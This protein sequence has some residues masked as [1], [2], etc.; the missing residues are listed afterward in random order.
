MDIRPIPE[1][2]GYFAGEDGNIYSNRPRAREVGLQPV[3][4]LNPG[5]Q[6]SGKYYIVNIKKNED[7]KYKS[8]R[9]H[10]LVCMAFH[11]VPIDHKATVSHIN[12]NWRN[13]KP[14]NLIWESMSDNH[15]RKKD[16]GT[17]DIGFKN[18]RASI[19][20]KTLKEIRRL[21]ELGTWTQKAIGDKFGLS[22]LFIT[23]IA[24]GHRYKGQG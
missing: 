19:D 10:R 13:N 9:V 8:Q 11:G 5:I 23:K 18:S 12:G 1:F 21:L 22:R 14:E 3:R 24:N 6:T 15:S 16:H 2:E 4:K 20:L 17:D 7:D